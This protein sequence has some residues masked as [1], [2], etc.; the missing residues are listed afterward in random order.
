MSLKSIVHLL[1]M[2][3][4]YIVGCSYLTRSLRLGSG[5]NW[6]MCLL[7]REGVATFQVETIGDAYM[8]VGG[9]PVWSLD[10][11]DHIATMALDLLHQSGK[12]RIRLLLLIAEF[13]VQLPLLLYAY[14]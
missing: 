14:A 8:C 3:K 7:N 11:A 10:H 9:A 5:Y 2:F 13:H 1:K 6:K 4:N 12:F